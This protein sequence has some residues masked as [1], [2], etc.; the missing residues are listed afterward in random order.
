MRFLE[1]A[2][3]HTFR[4]VPQTAPDAQSASALD[5]PMQ[6]EKERLEFDEFPRHSTF[7]LWKL[8]FGA[9]FVRVLV[10]RRTR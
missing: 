2:I 5:A 10:I 9:K 7:A 4:A 8:I 1:D 6:Q 3:L